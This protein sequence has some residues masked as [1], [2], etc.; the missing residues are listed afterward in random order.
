MYLS[1]HGE[2]ED[3]SVHVVMYTKEGLPET[4]GYSS[5]TY[6]KTTASEVASFLMS[7]ADFLTPSSQHTLLSRFGLMAEDFQS[8]D[9][10]IML[11][12]AHKGIPP[13]WNITGDSSQDGTRFSIFLLGFVY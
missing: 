8:L 10:D 6:K 9:H 4:L 11:A 2:P 12:M 7:Q 5:V 13:I 1:A 3:V